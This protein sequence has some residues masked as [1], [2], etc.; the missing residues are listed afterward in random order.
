MNKDVLDKILADHKLWLADREPGQRAKLAGADLRLADLCQADLKYADFHCADLTHANLYGSDLRH[1]D[2]SGADLIHANLTGVD[3]RYS[4]LCDANFKGA[5]LE[6][7]NLSVNKTVAYLC[8]GK[9]QMTLIKGPVAMI[10]CG[11]RWFTLA[12]AR[13]HWSPEN[14]ER[15]AEKTEKYGKSKIQQL[16]YLESLIA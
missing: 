13:E 15:W 5:N 16:N 12:E 7:A 2:L 14:I 8:S 3:L 1:A 4:Y 10:H 11:C 6:D 9:D